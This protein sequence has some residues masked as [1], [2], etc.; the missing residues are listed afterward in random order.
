MLGSLILYLKGM[1]IMMFQL[2][3]F[4]YSPCKGS[5]QG[6]CRSPSLWLRLWSSW[7]RVLCSLWF[8]VEGLGCNVPDCS[9]PQFVLE[10]AA[11]E[12]KVSGVFFVFAALTL[13]CSGTLSP[14]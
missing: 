3:G 7:F 9:R 8:R 6:D 10:A 14:I 1:R 11:C 13:I 12:E 4:Y 5:L 2:S